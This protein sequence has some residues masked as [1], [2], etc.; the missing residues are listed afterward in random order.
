MVGNK[1]FSAL[2]LEIKRVLWRFLDGV[3]YALLGYIVDANSCLSQHCGFPVFQ[4][5]QGL[6]LWSH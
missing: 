4:G 3:F 1:M 2:F 6:L 5:F